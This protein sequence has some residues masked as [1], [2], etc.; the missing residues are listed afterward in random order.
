MLF[1]AYYDL[2]VLSRR[3]PLAASPDVGQLDRKNGP[4]VS[5]QFA[6]EIRAPLYRHWTLYNA[7]THCPVVYGR[8]RLMEL[9]GIGLLKDFF[10]VTSASKDAI[11][12]LWGSLDGS[13]RRKLP[14][15][16]DRNKK[17]WNCPE[18]VEREFIR[19]LGL[20]GG[21]HRGW[22]ALAFCE[23]ISVAPG[24]LRL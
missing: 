11:E 20:D 2:F 17:R 9:K 13:L 18:L 10:A 4:S 1:V 5:Q 21:L 19:D 8:M 12:T 24:D 23:E 22:F 6:D 14:G 15:E 16:F 3:I 7:M